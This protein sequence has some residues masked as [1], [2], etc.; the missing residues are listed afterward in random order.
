MSSDDARVSPAFEVS[1]NQLDAIGRFFRRA[2]GLRWQTLRVTIARS[3]RDNLLWIDLEMTGL[4]PLEDVILQAAAV[5]TTADLEPLDQLAIDVAQPEEK[6]ARM[7]PFVREMHSRTGLLER[8]RRSTIDIHQAERI[9]LDRIA[10]LCPPPATLCGN[11]VWSDRRFVARYMPAL[12]KHLHY[13]LVDVSTLKVLAQRW[14]GD[15]SVFVK[16]AAG[17]HDATV[18]IQNSIEE[19]RYYRGTLFR[20]TSS[21]ESPSKPR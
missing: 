6:L 1:S 2:P 5:I 7:I 20:D 11:S 4:D 17:Q 3:S 10:P 16:P 15:A 9:L 18:D 14:Y 19:L 21:L 12:D 13:R 8:V